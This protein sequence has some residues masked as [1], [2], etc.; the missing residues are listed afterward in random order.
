[1]KTVKN[2]LDTLADRSLEFPE[3]VAATSLYYTVTSRA[4]R[5]REDG[6]R[7][8]VSIEQAII[9]IA[10]IA[11][12]IVILAVISTVVHNLAG[13]VTTPSVPDGTK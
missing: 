4:R 2:H 12:A 6:E 1:M 11:F 7:G 10:V 9:T 3:A 13:Q 5:A 8:A